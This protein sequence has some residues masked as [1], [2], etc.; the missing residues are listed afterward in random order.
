M[1][2]YWLVIILILVIV[3]VVTINLTTIWYIV[4]GIIA[5]ISSIFTDSILI[6]FSIFVLIGT[7][8]LVTT[9]KTLLIFFKNKNEETN[10]DRVVNMTGIVTEKIENSKYGEVKVDGKK[11]TAYSEKELEEGTLIKVLKIEGVKLKVKKVEE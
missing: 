3:E 7:L 6:Q 11:W 1:M 2:I 5:L 9:R 8:L 10:L 4:S